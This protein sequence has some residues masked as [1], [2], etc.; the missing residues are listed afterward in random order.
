LIFGIP[1][2]LNN[3]LAIGVDLKIMLLYVPDLTVLLIVD[4]LVQIARMIVSIF[5]I[6]NKKYVS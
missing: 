1:F 3:I 5:H 6:Q 4:V 2:I